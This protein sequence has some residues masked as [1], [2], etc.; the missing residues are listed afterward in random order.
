MDVNLPKEFPMP[1]MIVE[2]EYDMD[3]ALAETVRLVRLKNATL[4]VGFNNMA[5]VGIFLDNLHDTLKEEKINP[6]EKNFH[7]NIMVRT[8]E[9]T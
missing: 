9:Q 2:S 1:K 3:M 8:N 6:E 5:M 7:L 4:D